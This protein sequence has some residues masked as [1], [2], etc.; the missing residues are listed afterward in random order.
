MKNKITILAGMIAFQLCTPAYADVRICTQYCGPEDSP[1][2]VIIESPE[3]DG[4]GQ[5]HKP[6]DP[7]LIAKPINIKLL[8]EMVNDKEFGQKPE[9]DL[10]KLCDGSLIN[11]PA[12]VPVD[13]I[14][15][16]VIISIPSQVWP[17]L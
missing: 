4:D 10:I 16:G 6:I 3:S 11:C 7:K 9:C 12:P 8:C 14:K 13:P 17:P 2:E 15:P 1:G 5:I